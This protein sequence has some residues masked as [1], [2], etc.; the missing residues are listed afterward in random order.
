MV[1]LLNENATWDGIHVGLEYGREVSRQWS[2]ADDFKDPDIDR[3]RAEF[4]ILWDRPVVLMLT[5]TET[6]PHLN[7]I[8]YLETED[9]KI[10]VRKHYYF[11]L[12]LLSEAA[13]ALRIPLQSDKDYKMDET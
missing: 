8:V 7:D 5:E 1:A 2:I 6:G 4:C 3:Q 10:T 11:C 13:E 9:G 12:D